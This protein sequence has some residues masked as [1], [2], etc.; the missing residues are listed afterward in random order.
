MSLSPYRVDRAWLDTYFDFDGHIFEHLGRDAR[1][2]ARVE[3][4]DEP[5][6]QGCNPVAGSEPLVHGRLFQSVHLRRGGVDD[7]TQLIFRQGAETLCHYLLRS[8]KSRRRMRII[9]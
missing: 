5:V 6:E 8:R 2:L 3:P 7:L 1:R 9:R 4:R